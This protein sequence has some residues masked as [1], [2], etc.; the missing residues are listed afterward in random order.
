MSHLLQPVSQAKRRHAIIP[1]VAKND[2]AIRI[3]DEL[4]LLHLQGVLHPTQRLSRVRQVHVTLELIE[5]LQ[6]LYRIALDSRPHRLPDDAKEVDEATTAQETV[7]RAF[8]RR[9]AAPQLFKCSGLVMPEMVDVHVRM[10]PAP[11]AAEAHTRR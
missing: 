11:V 9:V 10:A 7:K 3:Q 5:G 8:P 2:L 1:V 4:R 6:T